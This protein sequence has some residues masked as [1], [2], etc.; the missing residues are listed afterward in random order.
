MTFYR[1]EE[2]TYQITFR[3]SIRTLRILNKCYFAF[4]L[5][6]ID[7][8]FWG[9]KLENCRKNTSRKCQAHIISFLLWPTFLS[10]KIMTVPYDRKAIT[11]SSFTNEVFFSL[12]GRYFCEFLVVVCRP[13]L[14]ILTL[15]ETKKCHFSH[16]FSDLASKKL[17]PSLLLTAVDQ[18][19]NKKLF[20][21]IHFEF[22][23]FSF[24]LIH[25]EL[26]W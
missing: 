25:L 7:Q 23:Y 16:L 17:C 8:I 26:K 10:K 20:L 12:P 6:F 15:F 21:K 22:A 1:S 3:L 2:E 13:V 19:T 14:Q 5:V 11:G 18:H 9:H 24:F 4:M